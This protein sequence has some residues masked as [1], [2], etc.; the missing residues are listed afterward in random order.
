[1]SASASARVTI[2]LKVGIRPSHLSRQ[3]A[4]P[5][6]KRISERRPTL[7]VDPEAP[8]SCP[9]ALLGGHRRRLASRY[10]PRL[11]VALAASDRVT[12]LRDS[13]RH[14]ACEAPGGPGCSDLDCLVCGRLR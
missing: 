14:R 7:D 9:R 3:L 13:S 12:A 4:A 1:M 5:I 10:G 6:A 11:S 8:A 2:E